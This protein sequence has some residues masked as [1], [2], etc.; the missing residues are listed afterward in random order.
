M[1]PFFFDPFMLLLIPPLIL[2]YYARSKVQ[3]TF[4]E[5]SQRMSSSGLTGAEAARKLLRTHGLENV[6]IQREEGNLSD[7]YDPR[8]RTLHLS[9]GVYGSSSLSALGV[10][11]HETGHAV[12]DKQGYMP[13]RFRKGIFPIAAFGNN[14]GPIIFMVGLMMMLFTGGGGAIARYV[15]LSG[16]ALFSCGAFFTLLTLPVELN[17]SKRALAMLTEQG[18]VTR[19]ERDDARKVLNAAALTYVAAAFMTVMMLTRFI[20][21]FLAL[22]DR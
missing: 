7:H 11:A 22:D 13:L 5:F 8:D 2:A 20:L 4:R 19:N 10:A 6:D 15:A 21:L 16:I 12:Q 1:I 17:A 18:I 3:N 9:Q 14:L